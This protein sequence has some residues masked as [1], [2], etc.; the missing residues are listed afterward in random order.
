LTNPGSEDDYDVKYFIG[1]A[2]IGPESR[3]C[4]SHGA[5][6]LPHVVVEYSANLEG[7]LDF[8]A[9]LKT[10]RDTA[11]DTGIFPLG[12]TRVRAYRADHYLVADGHADN[13]FVHIVMRIGH[14]RDLDTRKR[15]A[16]AVFD[17]ACGSLAAL[18]DAGPLGISFEVQ[19]IEPQL[20]FKKNNLHEYVKQRQA[21]GGAAKVAS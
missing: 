8:P 16:Q 9:L 5:V 18:Y 1:T 20:S 7:R 12:G 11:V 3:Q 21:Q 17:A 14:G 6:T 19:E 2:A 13:A 15:A 10:L 4:L